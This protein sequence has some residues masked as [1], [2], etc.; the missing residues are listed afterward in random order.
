MTVGSHQPYLF[1]YIG[2]WQLMNLADVYVIS[3][4]MQYIK[5]G[6]VNRNYLLVDGK[7]HRFSLEVMGVKSKSSIDEVEVGHNAK[8][9]LNTIFHAYKKAPYFTTTYPLIEEILLYQEK[10]LAKF[11]GHSIQRIA[12]ALEIT[13]KFIY[14]SD[15]QGKTEL[16]GQAKTIDICQRLQA[17]HYINAIGGESLYDKRDFEEVSIQ[18]NFLKSDEIRYQQFQ[19]S[20]IPNLSIIDIMMFNS[21]DEIGRMLQKYVL[22]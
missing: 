5:K 20:P 6:F 10:S 2:Y 18:L 19:N 9:I 1:P 14:L 15:L 13:P 4:S 3:D 17:N 21:K 7:R 22:L 16:C 11:L 12:Y 8:K